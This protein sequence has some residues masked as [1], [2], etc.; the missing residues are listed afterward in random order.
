[1]KI[2]AAIVTHNR[3]QLLERCIDHLQMQTRLPDSIVVINNGSTDGTVDMLKHRNIQYITQDNVGSA[4]GWYRCIA[5]AMEHHFDAIWLMDDDG[6][7]SQAALFAVPA[8]VTL[9]TI[10]SSLLTPFIL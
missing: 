1:M 4:G 7:P 9:T 2:L 5:H 10:E 8:F 6:F 3:C